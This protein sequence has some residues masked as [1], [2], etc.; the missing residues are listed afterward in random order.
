MSWRSIVESDVVTKINNTELSA[1][2][3]AALQGSQADPLTAS[4]TEITNLVRGYVPSQR[5]ADGTVPEELIPAA[6]DILIVSFLN[7]V[8]KPISESRNNAKNDAYRLLRDCQEGKFR[9]AI[10]ATYSTETPAGQVPNIIDRD[11]YSLNTAF[12]RSILNQDGI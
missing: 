10:P 8:N 9:I 1:Y 11:D 7:R 12:T 2:R 3:A 6:C 5:G 4:I